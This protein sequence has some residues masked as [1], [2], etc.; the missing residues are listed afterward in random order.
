MDTARTGYP[1]LYCSA[2]QSR[3]HPCL[4]NVNTLIWEIED[5]QI[6]QIVNDK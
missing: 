2:V 5:E 3:C 6:K 4:Q 1:E